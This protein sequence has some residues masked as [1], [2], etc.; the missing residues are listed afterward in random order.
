MCGVAGVGQLRHEQDE[1][2]EEQ[3]DKSSP[4][5]RAM[6]ISVGNGKATTSR[7]STA[8][9]GSIS[10]IRAVRP[11]PAKSAGDDPAAPRRYPLRAG[12]QA[13]ARCAAFR[14]RGTGG[15]LV[16]AP[17]VSDAC[18]AHGFVRLVTACVPGPVPFC[19]GRPRW[20]KQVRAAAAGLELPIGSRTN[21]P[22]LRGG[23]RHAGVPRA[24]RIQ[25]R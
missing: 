12:G 3:H 25:R 24:S 14:R 6:K 22:G 16:R 9:S 18:F 13:G 10:R 1:R 7:L 5:W 8:V 15:G 11:S 21:S 19:G 2:G 17:V 20:H 4:S 23:R